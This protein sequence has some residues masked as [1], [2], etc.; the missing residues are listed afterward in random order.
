[1]SKDNGKKSNSWM[2]VVVSIIVILVC[3][4]VAVFAVLK[5]LDTE[6]QGNANADTETVI[7]ATEETD[8]MIIS[9]EKVENVDGTS[10][11]VEIVQDT[12]SVEIIEQAEASYEE[13]L[14]AAMVVAVSMQYEDFIIDGIYLS[15]E[16]S[17][18]ENSQ[19]VCVLF[20]A[21]DDHQAVWSEPIDEERADSGTIDLYTKSLGFATFDIVDAAYVNT[22]DKQEI[23]IDDL[24]DLI[25]QS[26]LVSLYEH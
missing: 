22:M 17:T 16:N 26:M 5:M 1:M 11:N 23:G 14:A 2:I 15:D 4:A 9:G 24:E 8:N 7:S 3:I 18:R 10:E 12:G 19:G 20:T 13:W 21:G 6:E 25:S